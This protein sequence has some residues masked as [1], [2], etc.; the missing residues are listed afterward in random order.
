MIT[1]DISNSSAA[2]ICIQLQASAWK[3]EWVS[4]KSQ[5]RN[6]T[7][8]PHL[9]SLMAIG[10]LVGATALLC[11]NHNLSPKNFAVFLYRYK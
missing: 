10:A 9:V 4:T 1:G 2:A 11:Q 6:S 3:L 7:L 5:I 8:V